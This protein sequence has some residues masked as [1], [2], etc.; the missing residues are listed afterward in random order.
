MRAY[1][2]SFLVLVLFIVISIILGCSPQPAPGEPS[3]SQPTSVA[4]D[5]AAPTPTVIAPPEV[6]P[7]VSPCGVVSLG[8]I[9]V[10][11]GLK[12]KEG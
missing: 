6:S 9:G 10:V 4:T 5:P 8:L 12:R 11:L 1:K 2:A 7:C 3:N